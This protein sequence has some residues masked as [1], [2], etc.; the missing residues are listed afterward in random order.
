MTREDTT[1]L[2]WVVDEYIECKMLLRQKIITFKL[3]EMA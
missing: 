2:F 1:E 3:G